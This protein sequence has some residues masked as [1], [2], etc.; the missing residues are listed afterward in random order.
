MFE[1]MDN[2]LYLFPCEIT[3]KYITML[4]SYLNTAGNSMLELLLTFH[5]LAPVP[6]QSTV[7]EPFLLWYNSVLK[8]HNVPL[9]CMQDFNF[10]MSITNTG[11]ENCT[12]RRLKVRHTWFRQAGLKSRDTLHQHV[13]C[14]VAVHEVS[15]CLVVRA[16]KSD[17]HRS[18]DWKV[19]GLS[20]ICNRRI[21]EEGAYK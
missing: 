1:K 17:F 8:Q 18:S 21:Y 19:V 4:C 3:L 20:I 16:I 15:S 7:F 10:S 11:M 2:Y 6:V 5:I 9:S 13:G 12:T 14:T